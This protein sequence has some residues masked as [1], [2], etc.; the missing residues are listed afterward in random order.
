M[1]QHMDD[2]VRPPKDLYSLI[3]YLGI[4]ILILS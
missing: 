2:I 4:L 1:L 3:G